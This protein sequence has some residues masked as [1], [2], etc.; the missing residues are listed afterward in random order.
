MSLNIFNNY[1]MKKFCFTTALI[2][3]YLV[4]S[5]D[6]QAQTTRESNFLIGAWNYVYGDAIFHGDSVVNLVPGKLTGSDIKIWSEKYCSYIGRFKIDTTF[7]DHYGG[8]SY[9]L[10]GNNYEEQVLWHY[11][12]TSVGNKVKMLMELKNDTLIQTFPVDENGKG[13]KNLYYVQKY[14]RLD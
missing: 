14:V 12:P 9:T 6:V 11:N 7:M 3:S 1:N 10:D 8:G 4:F 5:V 13:N 2:I